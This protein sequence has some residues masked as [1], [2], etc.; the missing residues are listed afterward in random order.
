MAKKRIIEKISTPE[1]GAYLD[2]NLES[3]GSSSSSGSAAICRTCYHTPCSLILFKEIM[4][5]T[6]LKVID[7]FYEKTT[8][9]I[10]NLE[11]VA[12]LAYTKGMF[13][14]CRDKEA[15]MV[16]P[17]CVQEELTKRIHLLVN[18]YFNDWEEEGSENDTGNSE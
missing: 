16:L 15:P 13:P 6:F 4:E 5:R 18:S 2:E 7:E 8:L 9:S 10:E 12:A 11:E 14:L 17:K 3:E 1:K